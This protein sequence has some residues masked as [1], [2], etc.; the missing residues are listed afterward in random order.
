MNSRTTS[1]VIL[2]IPGWYV[3]FQTAVL[4]QLP[5][6]GKLNQIMAEGWSR[7][8]DALKKALAEALLPS[9]GNEQVKDDR[10]VLINT[11]NLEVPADYNHDTQLA[12]SKREN[13]REF[14]YYNEDITDWNFSSATT[15]LRPGREFKVKIF[16]IKATVSSED[17]LEFLRTQKAV[18]VGAQGLALTR[19]KRGEELPQ[20][21]WTVSF[22][23]KNY[24]F[25]DA[26]GDRRVPNM[27]RFSDGGWKFI[28]GRF[29][30]DWLDGNCLLCFCD[31]SA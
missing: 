19:D 7:N 23:E 31:L 11:F 4:E 28:L 29:G 14:A 21:R 27:R 10:F 15:I 12:S 5:R 30:V 13:G 9:K 2:E 6:P 18:L 24:L 16:Q 1:D 20:D 25:K 17:C 22:D 8:Q 3:K 26:V